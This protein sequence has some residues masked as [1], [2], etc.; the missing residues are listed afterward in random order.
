MEAI[1]WV[2]RAQNLFDVS[3][4]T[5]VLGSMTTVQ[6]T[7]AYNSYSTMFHGMMGGVGVNNCECMVVQ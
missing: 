4:I 7:I 3:E 6:P 2:P 5:Q 1:I